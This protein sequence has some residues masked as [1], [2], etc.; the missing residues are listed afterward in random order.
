MKN[1]KYVAL[2]LLSFSILG[3]GGD[4][5]SENGESGDVDSV[6]ISRI[7][8]S[9]GD[10]VSLTEVSRNSEIISTVGV[11]NNTTEVFSGFIE[12]YINTTCEGENPWIIR[13]L[14]QIEINPG[15]SNIYLSFRSCLDLNV[16]DTELVGNIYG[17]DQV[18]LVD[19]DSYAFSI[20]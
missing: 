20:N 2:I 19:S 10:G 13:D 14:E 12:F 11:R 15:T 4:G 3:C 1:I 7:L 16:T 18:E 6:F 5:S 8:I 17:P 9:D